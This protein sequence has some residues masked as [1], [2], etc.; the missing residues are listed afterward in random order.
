M[1]KNG[2]GRPRSEENDR[3]I[4]AAVREILAQDGFEGLRFDA[5]ARVA[6][7]SR[8]SIYRRW[9][10]KADLLNDIAYETRWDLPT[11]LIEGDLR[12][13][14]RN[15]LGYV[16]AYYRKPE[17]RAAVLGALASMPSTERA[18][19]E[20]AVEAERDTRGAV[21]RL[22]AEAQAA[23]LMRPAVQADALY[24]L[25]MGSIVYRAIFSTQTDA[26]RLPDD[27][28]DVIMDGVSAGQDS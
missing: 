19:S 14:I 26:D 6:G 16:L 17:I 11:E 8:P 28:V 27:L 20:L 22:V 15:V 5:L 23:G 2:R 18:P 10:N 4:M 9:A 3:A 24:D 13:T 1:T 7:V 12:G 21:A 25:I